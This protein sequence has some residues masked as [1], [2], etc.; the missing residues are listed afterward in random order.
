MAVLHQIKACILHI[1]AAAGQDCMVSQDKVNHVSENHAFSICKGFI[2]SRAQ[3]VDLTSEKRTAVVRPTTT[4]LPTQQLTCNPNCFQFTPDRPSMIPTPTTAPTMHRLPDCGRPYLPSTLIP[5]R[6]LRTGSECMMKTRSE[7][8]EPM[9]LK[10][11]QSLYINA[12]LG[13]WMFGTHCEATV[14]VRAV[15]SS[16]AKPRVGVSLASFTPMARMV[17]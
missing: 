9:Q 3:L 4:T 2:N 17:W 5:A 16:A 13:R 6:P 10:R 7:I 12:K 8:S 1:Q 15:A 14:T 11:N